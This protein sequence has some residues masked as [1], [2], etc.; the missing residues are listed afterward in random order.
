MYQQVL[1]Y[2]CI[3]VLVSDG[4]ASE[5]ATSFEFPAGVPLGQLR[6]FFNADSEHHADVISGTGAASFFA[7][8]RPFTNFVLLPSFHC[9]QGGPFGVH[10]SLGGGVACNLLGLD[11]SVEQQGQD[12]C[13]DFGRRTFSDAS[14]WHP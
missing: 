8:V 12:H 14:K 2:S 1:E 10:G 3:V 6:T 13:A 4:V 11:W 5:D 7:H 9:T